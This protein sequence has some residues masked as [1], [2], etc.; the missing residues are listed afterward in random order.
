MVDAPALAV[1]DGLWPPLPVLVVLPDE[2]QP[3]AASARAPATTSA[4]AAGR[5]RELRVMA[6]GTDP[7]GARFNPGMWLT[8]RASSVTFVPSGSSGR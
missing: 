7:G 1:V 3:A 5:M 6:T 2:P 8:S 4:A